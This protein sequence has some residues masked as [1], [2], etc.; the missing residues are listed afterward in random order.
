MVAW[1]ENSTSI[2]CGAVLFD[3]PFCLDTEAKS[4]VLHLVLVEGLAVL[5]LRYEKERGE[6]LSP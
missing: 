5:L 3:L 6:R 1:L 4:L 2:C